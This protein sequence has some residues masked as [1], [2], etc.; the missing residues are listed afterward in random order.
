MSADSAALA[1]ECVQLATPSSGVSVI[2]KGWWVPLRQ[3]GCSRRCRPQD[4]DDAPE[5]RRHAALFARRAPGCSTGPTHSPSGSSVPS[6]SVSHGGRVGIKESCAHRCFACQA[7]AAPTTGPESRTT[8]NVTMFRETARTSV[9]AVPKSTIVNPRSS[10]PLSHG[11]RQPYRRRSAGS[12]R[13]A[14]SPR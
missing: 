5:A 12:F 4:D 1:P 2:F 3:C 7:D 8:L 11:L 13:H 6:E 14:A 10:A 9:D